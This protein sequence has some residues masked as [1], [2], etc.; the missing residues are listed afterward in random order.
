MKGFTLDRLLELRDEGQSF[1]KCASTL[2]KEGHRSE[3]G[4]AYSR[5]RLQLVLS[6]WEGPV[7]HVDSSN[8][9]V[10][11][12]LFLNVVRVGS[13]SR[14]RRTMELCSAMLSAYED[15]PLGSGI[16]RR[17]ELASEAGVRH[18][19]ERRY[20]PLRKPNKDAS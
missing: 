8:E 15:A 4:T 16:M 3:G 10:S 6:F 14:D 13:R 20:A 1:A 7:C 5:Q 12:H 2:A 19:K 18:K 11:M 9:V 17:C